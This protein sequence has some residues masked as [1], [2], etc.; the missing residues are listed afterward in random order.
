MITEYRQLYN[1]RIET[2]V[3]H[4][5]VAS[6]EK[7]LTRYIKEEF[8]KRSTPKDWPNPYSKLHV[9]VTTREEGRVKR[10]LLWSSSFRSK[11]NALLAS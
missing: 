7:E 4:I 10:D 5:T 6:R 3:N 1:T 8:F 11:Q 2:L 9:C